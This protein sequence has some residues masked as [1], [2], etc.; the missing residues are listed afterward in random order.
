MEI[1]INRFFAK[2]ILLILNFCL[3]EKVLRVCQGYGD[4]F[5][6]YIELSWEADKELNQIIVNLQIN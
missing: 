3:C 6:Y 2:L 1:E 4:D 5:E